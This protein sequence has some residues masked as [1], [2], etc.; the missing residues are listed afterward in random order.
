[1]VP[2]FVSN[3]QIMSND[4]TSTVNKTLNLMFLLLSCF[5][6]STMKEDT[7]KYK[8]MFKDIDFENDDEKIPKRGT[9]GAGLVIIDDKESE[10]TPIVIEIKYNFDEYKDEV[11]KK[12]GQV[13]NWSEAINY[14]CK[15]EDIFDENK[16]KALKETMESVTSYFSRILKVKHD[17]LSISNLPRLAPSNPKA[18]HVIEVTVATFSTTT[19][20]SSKMMIRDYFTSR[21]LVSQIVFCSS[22]LPTVAENKNTDERY[23]FNVCVHET[24]HSIGFKSSLFNEWVDKSTGLRYKNPIKKFTRGQYNKVF[25]SLCTPK[26]KEVV[27]R[28]FGRTTDKY[29]NELCLELEDNG[30]SGTELSHPKSTLFRQDL[31]VGIASHDSVLSEIVLSVLDDMGWYT[32][33]WS[34][35]EQMIWGAKEFV[36]DEEFKNMIEKPAWK[37]LP[38]SYITKPGEINIGIDYKSYGSY[39][40]ITYNRTTDI[41]NITQYGDLYLPDD[42]IIGR[43]I[44][45]D[46]VPLQNFD[47]T[48]GKDE[49]AFVNENR[50]NATCLKGIFD[51]GKFIVEINGDKQECKLGNKVGEWMCPDPEKIKKIDDYLKQPPH[52]YGH[53]K[54]YGENGMRNSTKIGIYV[55]CSCVVLLIIVGIS[56]WYCCFKHHWLRC[57]CCKSKQGFNTDDTS[58]QVLI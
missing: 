54:L 15:K 8:R 52:D 16:E 37:N 22:F 3:C 47:N 7:E 25:T 1:M 18:D 33:N 30:G 2:L 53:V 14:T 29:G 23:F 38:K 51:S 42:N 12:V 35:A 39:E 5:S 49:W 9:R 36:S 19:L 34:M 28:R 11:C 6:L 21:P 57:C 24:I 40:G 56:I 46:H 58:A 48:C 27:Q 44:V 17:R 20:G 55:G 31:M 43:N 26:A 32:V 4:D 41:Y 10:R 45:Y 50:T 13:I